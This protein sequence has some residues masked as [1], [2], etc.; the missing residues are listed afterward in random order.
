MDPID[1]PMKLKSKTP[2]ATFL[3]SIFPIPVTTASHSVQSQ[4]H[5]IPHVF[6][7]YL[8]E[9]PADRLAMRF[10]TIRA[11]DYH[12]VALEIRQATDFHT[13]VTGSGRKRR[14]AEIVTALSMSPNDLTR[15]DLKTVV[16]A[17]LLEV[18]V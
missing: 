2:M 10:F 14:H 3:E 8:P 7:T 9:N 12:R 17:L 4:N 11:Q 16:G 18:L 13:V 5:E 6:T 1:P 15:D